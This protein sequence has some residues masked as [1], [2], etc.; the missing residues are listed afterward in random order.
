MS[1]TFYHIYKFGCYAS[2]LIGAALADS[3]VGKYRTILYVGI[4][5]AIG[6]AILAF[7]AV[8]NGPEGIEGFQNMS[9]TNVTKF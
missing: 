2:A 1:T 9:V 3:Y 5:Y 6:Q 8:G 7:G 4:L